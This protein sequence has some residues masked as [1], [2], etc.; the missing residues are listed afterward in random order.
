MRSDAQFRSNNYYARLAQLL[1]IDPTRRR[2]V[3]ALAAGYRRDSQKLWDALNTWLQDEAGGRGLPS[4][5]S[6]DW[7]AHVGIPISQALLREEERLALRELFVRYRLRP[8]QQLATSDMLRLLEDWVPGSDLSAN[9]KRLVG[10]ASR[11]R[12]D[13][14]RV[15]PHGL[16][17]RAKGVIYPAMRG[18]ATA[19]AERPSSVA[20]HEEE[21]EEAASGTARSLIACLEAT[22]PASAAC[23]PNFPTATPGT[24]SP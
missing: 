19:D 2:E 10:C 4:A 9:L 11:A 7:R 12:R 16:A 21:E 18:A 17:R 20:Q 6:L 15:L 1:G 23:V 14:R 8:G 24:P 22:G 3:A 5:Y 13:T